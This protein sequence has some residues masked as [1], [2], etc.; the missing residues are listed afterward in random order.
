MTCH[1]S[2]AASHHRPPDSHP[3]GFWYF[4]PPSPP[5][6]TPPQSPATAIPQRQESE[7]RQA[8]AAPATSGTT[9][10]PSHRS[11]ACKG[12]ADRAQ[13]A[14]FHK[15]HRLAAAATVATPAKAWQAGLKVAAPFPNPTALRRQPRR[16]VGALAKARAALPPP[17][18]IPAFR[19]THPHPPAAPL[20]H[21]SHFT[22]HTS[23]RQPQS[24][25]TKAGTTHPSLSRIHLLPIRPDN[26]ALRRNPPPHL[27]H[28][29]RI[30]PGAAVEVKLLQVFQL[31]EPLHGFAA[32]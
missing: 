24:R 3:A 31:I 8:R 5:Q 26:V 11:R 32:F 29:L 16:T 20:V 17:R 21:T 25:I 10:P 23:A 18:I 27:P 28:R 22:L 15:P 9:R 2:P 6:K 14:A 19:R 13:K 4:H 7:L 30:Q 1:V 12:V